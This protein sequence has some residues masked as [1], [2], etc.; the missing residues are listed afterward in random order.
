M[1][2]IVMK[3]K[4]YTLCLF[5]LLFFYGCKSDKARP[6]RQFADVIPEEI[7]GNV[8]DM[9]MADSAAITIVVKDCSLV[10]ELRLSSW[11]DS[12][13]YLRLDSQDAALIGSVNKF[14]RTNDAVFLL[15]RY[16]TK[17]VKKFSMD[18]KFIA[19]IGK[20]GEGPGEYFEPTDF[21]ATDSL[22]IVYDQFASRFN[23]YTLDGQYIHSRNLPFLCLRF[24]QFS[25]DNLFFCTLDADNQ[26]LSSIEDFSIFQTDSAFVINQRG[27]YR[28]RGK[29]TS[30]ISDYNF[31]ELNGRLY[32]HPPYSGKIY[33]INSDGKCT[34]NVR[35]DFGKR[36]LPE[37]FLLEENWGKY[38][39]ESK[40]DRYNF[41][42]GE[43]LFV[44]D[45]VYFAYARQ[46]KLYRCF[47]SLKEKKAVGSSVI[48]NDVIPIFPFT[49]LIGVG[50]NCIVGYVYPH[51]IVT[52][53]DHFSAEEWLD[54]VGE[55]S[56]NI[57]RQI[58]G[59]D[60]PILLWFH[61][62]K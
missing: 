17:S 56:V 31:A 42:L 27:F 20:Q 52:A 2:F 49:N 47:Y 1:K 34:L 7:E 12:I 45:V 37:E 40:G 11:V 26:H 19:D 5:A 53:R 50:G 30:I 62:K 13:S 51:D 39:D 18:G 44:D 6:L 28:K 16:K 55:E 25:A 60:N 32:Y 57:A 46:H 41:F 22:V 15:D 58:K 10:K 36:Q 8:Q 35:L 29:Y 33:E 59:E 3:M 14:I 24:H 21:I 38:K 9:N 43:F 54:L 23:Y 61:M 4:N 48:R